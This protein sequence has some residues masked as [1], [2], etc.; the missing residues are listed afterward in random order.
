MA[1]YI[2]IYIN[3]CVYICM[4]VETNTYLYVC[5]YIYLSKTYVIYIRSIPWLETVQTTMF[6]LLY[7][8]PATSIVA[9]DANHA[10][11]VCNDVIL[12]TTRYVCICLCTTI[13]KQYT[14]R[15][16]TTLYKSNFKNVKYHIVTLCW[17][18]SKTAKQC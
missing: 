4:Y 7:S 8:C 13:E 18:E 12:S 11:S 15:W 16:N 6:C 2:Y 14:T 5:I 17:T 3:I 1:I 9:L 10:M